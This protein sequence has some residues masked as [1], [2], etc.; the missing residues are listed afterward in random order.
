MKGICL[1]F[2]VLFQLQQNYQTKLLNL[3]V[4]SVII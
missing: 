1:L 4:S 3:D 2:I